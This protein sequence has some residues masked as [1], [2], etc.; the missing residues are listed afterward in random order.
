MAS[1]KK[2][3]R[4]QHSGRVTLGPC[5]ALG[6]DRVCEPLNRISVLDSGQTLRQSYGSCTCGRR[7]KVRRR[8]SLQSDIDRWREHVKNECII[9]RSGMRRVVGG[10][11][12]EGRES[13]FARV[14]I[15]PVGTPVLH[16]ATSYVTM[17]AEA[18]AAQIEARL[19]M[20][21]AAAH[22]IG[23]AAN[24]IGAPVRVLA[25][26]LG[27]IAPQ[28]L[29]NPLLVDSSGDWTYEEGCLSLHVA[30]TR[31]LVHRPREI[32][33]VA[34]IPGRSIVVIEAQELLGRVLQ[35][36]L[37]HLEGIEYVQ[38][39][40]GSQ[41]KRVYDAMVEAG[42]DISWLPERPYPK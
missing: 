29:I 16:Q 5:D 17:D 24:Q 31:A 18:E 26:N 1:T 2:T 11:W 30:N 38:R 39:L 34:G 13:R 19:L 35:H 6:E 14:G 42:V 4:R 20:S 28:V 40:V 23:L 41:R 36:E 27:H 8:A 15:V 10:L 32:T 22:G 37:D 9:D 12:P 25:H 33:V 21:M 7:F 3:K